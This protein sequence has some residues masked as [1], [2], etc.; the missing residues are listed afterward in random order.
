V[1][2]LNNPRATIEV[3]GCRQQVAAKLATDAERARLWP[4]LV[5]S[6]PPYAVFARRSGH[7]PRVFILT[8][9]PV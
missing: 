2:L 5:A 8:T 4:T 9:V 1:N 3:K 6:F 7:D